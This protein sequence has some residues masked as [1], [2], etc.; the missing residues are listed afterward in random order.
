MTHTV[1]NRE[2][3]VGDPCN[4]VDQDR[5]MHEGTITALQEQDG[6]HYAE[7]EYEK[8]GQK[9]QV[10]WAVHNTSPEAHSW[11]HVILPETETE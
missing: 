4:Y 7:I 8:D 6:N 1:N 5:M 2:T 3:R 10:T 11:N 9:T